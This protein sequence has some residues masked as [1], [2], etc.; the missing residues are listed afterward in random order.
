MAL[1]IKEGDR[2]GFAVFEFDGAMA[3]GEISFSLQSLASRNGLFLSKDGAWEKTPYYFKAKQLPSVG[4]TTHYLV[5]PEVVNHVR[6]QDTVEIAPPPNQP[7]F[8]AAEM[9]WENAA[10]EIQAGPRNGGLFVPQRPIRPPIDN[11]ASAKI[12]EEQEWRR[13]DEERRANEAET[14]QKDA[15]EKQPDA[16]EGEGSRDK[17][18]A[19]TSD[20][21][22]EHWK[23][24]ES[25]KAWRGVLP[26]ALL[27]IVA[28]AAAMGWVLFPMQR[29]ALFGG[30]L[31][32]CGDIEATAVCLQQA[33]DRSP[34]DA[35]R[36][37]GANPEAATWSQGQK[38]RLQLAL[39]RAGDA[40]ADRRRD[41]RTQAES[42]L[43]LA[44]QNA[45][46]CGASGCAGGYLS[47]FGDDPA[48]SGLRKR[49][50]DDDASC[51]ME[52]DAARAALACADAK[53]RD[54]SACD[55]GRDCLDGY[56]RQFPRGSALDELRRRAAAAQTKCVADAAEKS[57]ADKAKDCLEAKGRSHD[58][59]NS[60]QCLQAYKARYPS[61]RSLAGLE[62]MAA[63]L[64]RSCSVSKIESDARSCA[65]A[66]APC[67]IEAL[68]I[69]PARAELP[70]G[71]RSATL[72]RI[73]G[74]A[75]EKCSSTPPPTDRPIEPSPPPTTTPYS[76]AVGKGCNG[77][78]R[79][80]VPA[81]MV[82]RRLSWSYQGAT[83][84]GEIDAQQNLSAT[85]RAADGRAFLADGGFPMNVVMHLACDVPIRF[86]LERQ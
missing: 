54:G 63:S 23:Q 12:V 20:E 67:Q 22:K 46:A 65:D 2:P 3:A 16:G 85:G 39:Q 25:G 44:E 8:A 72:E 76:G 73:A 5:G 43:A 37:C 13:E 62:G 55:L 9:T 14:R 64:D 11:G 18:Q 82:G 29:C 80:S 41:A 70:P 32:G 47:K 78:P 17:G 49:V 60:K 4:G 58:A 81:Q 56:A 79:Q 28:A 77:E 86:R 75:S 26:V 19:L 6:N 50:D 84:S 42:C 7:A 51:G 15:D 27:L 69:L 71:E 33:T 66:T 31:G 68:C 59:C 36:A 83:W 10:P 61:G 35:V 1:R 40:C 38:A 34:C 24:Q 57:A 74:D 45:N 48:A 21:G 52:R 30:A 53:D